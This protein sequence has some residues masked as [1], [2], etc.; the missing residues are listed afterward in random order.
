MF[1]LACTSGIKKG[2]FAEVDSVI[3]GGVTQFTGVA[4]PLFLFV[5]VSITIRT[6]PYF[7]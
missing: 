6:S 5:F 2:H 7:S 3:N 1:K 4:L